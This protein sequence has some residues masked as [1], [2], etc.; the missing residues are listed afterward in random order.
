MN[1]WIVVLKLLPESTEKIK[2]I[3]KIVF[4]VNVIK[5]T[6]IILFFNIES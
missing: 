4:G 6:E 5:E 2:H 1:H 3:L